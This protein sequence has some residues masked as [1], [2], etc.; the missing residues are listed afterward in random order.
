MIDRAILRR[1]RRHHGAVGFV[2]SVLLGSVVT[3]WAWNTIAVELFQ[4]PVFQFK[5]AL[6]FQAV[7]ALIVLTAVSARRFRRARWFGAR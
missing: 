5:H 3:L 4:A 1:A 2:V 6:A 7:V